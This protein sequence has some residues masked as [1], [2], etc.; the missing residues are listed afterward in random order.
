MSL[1]R[2]SVAVVTYERPTFVTRCLDHLLAQ[3][4]P[5]SE[6]IVVDSS[7]TDDTGRLVRDRYPTVRY[8]VCPAGRGATATARNIGYTMTTGEVLAFIDDDAFAEPNWLERLLPFFE[9][10]AV[11]GVGGRQIRRQPG[12][13]EEGVDAIGL[14]KEDGTLTGHFAADPGG[15]VSVDHLLGANMSFRRAAL[16]RIGGIRDGYAG[17]CI[18]EETDLC[19]QVSQAGYRLIYTPDA[20]VEHVAAP[21]AKGERFDLRYAYWAQ[22]NHLILLIRNFGLRAPMVRAY[23]ASSVRQAGRDSSARFG[24]AW[25]RAKGRDRRGAVRA[26][27]AGVARGSV[28]LVASVSGVA[29]GVRLARE[30]RRRTGRARPGGV[31]R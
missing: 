6:I 24:T 14:L 9:D 11:G 28:A 27:G 17:T 30:D 15:P 10:P 26:S 16:D 19:L 4:E 25:G 22:K 8:E 13:L 18:R 31:G 20:V 7:T 3:S 23:L 2:A 29:A 21:Y 12:E 5:P 1:P